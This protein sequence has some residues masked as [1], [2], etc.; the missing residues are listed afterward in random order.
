MDLKRIATFV[1]VAELQSFTEAAARLHTVQPAISRQVQQLEQEVGAP[2]LWRTK[3]TVRTTAAGAIFLLRAKELLARAGEIRE[4]AQRANRGEVGRLAIGYLGSATS[5]FLP[6]LVQRYRRQYPGVKVTVA[7]MTPTEQI[8]AF[9]K[10]AIDVGFTRPVDR[11][12]RSR[13]QELRIYEDQL[14]VA[15]SASDRRASRR[16][17]ALRELASEPFVLFERALAPG[18]IDLALSACQR[19]GF[20]P[21]VA[22]E[23]PLMQT[24]LVMVAAGMGVS[25]VPGCVRHLGVNG[26]SLLDFTPKAASVDLVMIWPKTHIPPTVQEFEGLVKGQL[27][28]VRQQMTPPGPR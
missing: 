18:L 28:A 25:L 8:Q 12:Q 11:H 3:R 27:P 24:V 16:S 26:I 23:S 13:F 15:V 2:L 10:G 4:E 5:P 9:E 21:Q 7:E 22:G 1:T 20:S 19:A 17:L 14:K 6:D